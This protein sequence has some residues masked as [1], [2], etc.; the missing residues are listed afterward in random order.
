L[1]RKA[2]I[3]ATLGA[4][5]L[6]LFVGDRFT[7]P[8]D[9]QSLRAVPA[10]DTA[11][12]QEVIDTLLLRYGVNRALVKMW[13]VT[14]PDKTPVRIEQRIPVQADFLSLVFNHDLNR[15]LAPFGAHVIA[16]ER[17]K[18]NTITMHIV[19]GGM[20]IRSMAFVLQPVQ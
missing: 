6:L 3:A 12:I 8:R 7:G 13:R 1:G 20:T 2:A 14:T 4:I 19:R 10:E 9:E 11:G 18:E 17:T 5:S 15:R 16:T